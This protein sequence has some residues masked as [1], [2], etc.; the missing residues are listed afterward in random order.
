VKIP[1]Q[2]ATKAISEDGNEYIKVE[3]IRSEIHK[4]TFGHIYEVPIRFKTII[5]GTLKSGRY[6]I[7]Y[8]HIDQDLVDGSDVLE[9]SWTPEEGD[10]Q[11]PKQ[12]FTC[13]ADKQHSNGAVPT[14]RHHPLRSSLEQL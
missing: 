10:C 11:H 6:L 9:F 2:K 1:K 14:S 4:I 5:Q 12:C 7:R 8:A 13:G 3:D